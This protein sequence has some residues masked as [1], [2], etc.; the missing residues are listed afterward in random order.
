M[1]LQEIKRSHGIIYRVR[2]IPEKRYPRHHETR[3]KCGAYSR[4]TPARRHLIKSNAAIR[5]LGQEL[6]RGGNTDA[7]CTAIPKRAR[8]DGC[9]CDHWFHGGRPDT[10]RRPGTS[11]RSGPQGL[12]RLGRTRRSRLPAL[13]GRAA[14][15]VPEIRQT[16]GET[17]EGLLEMAPQPSRL[18]NPDVM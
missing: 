5:T 4:A 6:R 1:P 9:S 10:A 15:T 18:T 13:S 16:Q 11:L 3:S 8:L 2:C 7:C 12:S 14:R 17:A